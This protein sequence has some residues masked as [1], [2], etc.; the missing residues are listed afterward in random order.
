MS[1]EGQQ[2]FNEIDNQ[3][4]EELEYE[5]DEDNFENVY[6]E[7]QMGVPEQL[8]NNVFEE[9]DNKLGIDNEFDNDDKFDHDDG[10]GSPDEFDVND[11]IENTFGNARELE[12]HYEKQFEEEFEEEFIEDGKDIE[13]GDNDIDDIEKNIEEVPI[14][15][16]TN[17]EK[18]MN[19]SK[20]N[21]IETLELLDD[22]SE[23][24]NEV[25]EIEP[26]KNKEV[27]MQSIVEIGNTAKIEYTSDPFDDDE[28]IE[29]GDAPNDYQRIELEYITLDNE[30]ETLNQIPIY[31]DFTEMNSGEGTTLDNVFLKDEIKVNFDFMK[32]FPPDCKEDKLYNEFTTLFKTFDECIDL[33]FDII[34]ENISMLLDINLSN[35]NIHLTFNDLLNFT[36]QSDS[37]FSNEL[38]LR[39]IL[40]NYEKLKN[41]SSNP[42]LYGFLSIK[43][44]ITRAIKRQFHILCTS[45]SNGYKLENINDI[46]NNKE[47][48]LG[49]EGSEIDEERPSKI[50]KTN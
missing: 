50:R 12:E 43:V 11:D 44:W 6:I 5:S 34:F 42:D 37:R 2:H 39:E 1:Q 22:F 13:N 7:S 36:I 17:A 32:L 35:F 4:E 27:K 19:T 41:Q 48:C 25:E 30:N 14:D 23:S 33:K 24:E 47:L 20:D 21:G 16:V 3:K 45:L 18:R 8:E 10:S 40:E 15:N 26:T 9:D 49:I 31:L 38:N 28:L 46:I 29:Y